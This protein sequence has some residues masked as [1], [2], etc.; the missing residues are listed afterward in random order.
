M[1][2]QS[3]KPYIAHITLGALLSEQSDEALGAARE[4]TGDTD[5]IGFTVTVPTALH[6]GGIEDGGTADRREHWR[7]RRWSEP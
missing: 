1:T 2:A 4:P 5:E 3:P 6:L 7:R